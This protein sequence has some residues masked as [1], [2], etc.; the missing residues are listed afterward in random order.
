MTIW[1]RLT[2]Q[3]PDPAAFAADLAHRL[4]VS[5]ARHPADPE[6][7]VLALGSGDLDV[8]RWR[9]EGPNDDPLPGGRLVFEPL[10][11]AGG[12]PPPP[13]RSDLVVVAVGWA[14]VDLDRAEQELD[15]WLGGPPADAERDDLDPHLGAR[16]RIRPADGLPGNAIALL[17][18]TTEGRLAASLARDGE[19]PC[20]L[21]LRPRDGLDPWIAAAYR[22]GVA[23]ST[24]A[25]GPFGASVLVAARPVAGPHLVIVA[26]GSPGAEAPGTIRP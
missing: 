7:F 23:A 25:A 17:E 13:D 18:P 12:D 15:E 10:G 20:A 19:G 2:W 22:R 16:V 3:A 1:A 21:Y 26:D 8:V 6:A 11:L 24:R 4:G 5:A 9:R 14:T